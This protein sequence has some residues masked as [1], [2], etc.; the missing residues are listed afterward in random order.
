MEMRVPSLL[1]PMIEKYQ[2]DSDDV[3]LFRFHKMYC[4]SDSFN[5]NV[6]SGIRDLCKS[7]GMAKEDYYC[8]YTFR[9]TWGTVA[10]NDCGASWDDVAFGM[11][12]SNGHEVTRG[13]VKID[14][15]P[16]WELNEKVV[17]RCPRELLWSM[18]SCVFLVFCP[19]PCESVE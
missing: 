12:H 4:S 18:F 15:S 16:A 13:Y 10:Q 1:L 3:Y 14:F 9:H 19:C 17:E 7:M 6:N 11:N 5:A 2:A 8:V